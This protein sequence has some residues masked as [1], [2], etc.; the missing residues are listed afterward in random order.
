MAENQLVQIYGGGGQQN[1]C[2]S[3]EGEML[4]WSSACEAG[5]TGGTGGG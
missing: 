1:E 4:L 5:G 2:Q 3:E